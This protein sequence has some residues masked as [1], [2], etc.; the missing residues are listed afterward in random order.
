MLK[1]FTSVLDQMLVTIKCQGSWRRWA[2]LVWTHVAVR[3]AVLDVEHP[4]D[5]NNTSF[6][7]A[8]GDLKLE[9]CSLASNIAHRP[10]TGGSIYK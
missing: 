3:T 2:P 9:P 7:I 8:R 5:V 10:S 1:S 4:C 6:T